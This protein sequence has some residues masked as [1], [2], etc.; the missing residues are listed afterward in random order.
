[1]TEAEW[2]DSNDAGAMLRFLWQCQGIQPSNVDL[3]FGGDVRQSTL[4]QTTVARLDR[5]LHRFYPASCR[6]IWRHLPQ[7]A[8]RRGV[9]LAEQYLAGKATSEEL[10]KFNWDVEGAAF[11]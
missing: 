6:A 2:I 8:S 11:N 10:N 9:E 7:E 1:M 4:S 3:R 5:Q